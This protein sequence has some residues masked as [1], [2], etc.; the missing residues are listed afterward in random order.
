M[1]NRGTQCRTARASLGFRM[2]NGRIAVLPVSKMHLLRSKT[3][4]RPIWVFRGGRSAISADSRRRNDRHA[5]SSA[6]SVRVRVWWMKGSTRSVMI[7]YGPPRGVLVL[8]AIIG[9]VP[10]VAV[11][12]LRKDTRNARGRGPQDQYSRNRTWSRPK[13]SAGRNATSWRFERGRTI[14][15][16]AVP[17]QAHGTR[18]YGIA[19]KP[20]DKTTVAAWLNAR[21]CTAQGAVQAAFLVVTDATAT[22]PAS[23]PASPRIAARAANGLKTAAFSPV[24]STSPAI[25]VETPVY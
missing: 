17:A 9:S 11:Q 5:W 3:C 18:K 14:F 16:T 8:I 2:I 13:G 24:D 22:M 21:H 4:A 7:T 10:V 1:S 19:K 25:A 15:L 6:G 12:S 23:V 20:E